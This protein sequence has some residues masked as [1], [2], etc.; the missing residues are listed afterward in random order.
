M[1]AIKCPNCG[2]EKVKELTE[3]KY[4]CTA[5]DNI[6][7]VHNLSKEFQQTDEHISAMHEDLKSTIES[8]VEKSSGRADSL[9]NMVKSADALYDQDH[10]EEAEDIYLNIIA[11]YAWSYEGYYGVIYCILED[12]YYDPDRI[13]ALN[14]YYSDM[15]ICDDC[16]PE[17]EAEVEA[18][19]NE[20]LAGW[21]INEAEGLQDDRERCVEYINRL[22]QRLDAAI[23]QEEAIDVELSQ[24]K[25]EMEAF[26]NRNESEMEVYQKGMHKRNKFIKIISIVGGIVLVVISVV[27]LINI[28]KGLLGWI[29]HTDRP[30]SFGEFFGFIIG[31]IFKIIISLAV[32]LGA[33][34]GALRLLVL[35]FDTYNDN[36][37]S[38][39]KNY[40]AK[41]KNHNEIL[42]SNQR[43]YDNKV[44]SEKKAYGEKCRLKQKIRQYDLLRNNIEETLS[45]IDKFDVN[46]KETA[47]VIDYFSKIDE[48]DSNAFDILERYFDN[49]FYDSIN[50][51]K[52]FSLKNQRLK[53]ETYDGK[54]KLNIDVS[55]DCLWMEKVKDGFENES[56][57][58][59]LHNVWEESPH[60]EEGKDVSYFAYLGI[61]IRDE[62]AVEV[63][64]FYDLDEEDE[65]DMS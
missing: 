21:K 34:L 53:A 31:G 2:S 55:D 61:N 29:V 54:I 51:F 41:L 9:V 63:Y 57:Y 62:K 65:E 19:V 38:E 18:K 30:S 11:R 3:E 22:K 50:H 37:E 36:L 14:D 4:A 44:E 42:E 49:E 8:T 1:E 12:D 5:C 16:T 25:E 17:I 48:F 43:N 24:K 35:I 40:M 7:L 23:S 47:I 27:L 60:D 32:I 45:N 15:K 46:G 26:Q 6:F 20:L 33:G 28:S 58:D 56:T 13:K 10:I 64:A 52:V 39:Q 59:E